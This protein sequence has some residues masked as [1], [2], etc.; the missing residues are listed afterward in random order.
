MTLGSTCQARAPQLKSQKVQMAVSII[1]GGGRGG[2][3]GGGRGEGG[4]GRGEGGGGG[5]GGRGEGVRGGG[6]EAP[7]FMRFTLS[8]M[9]GSVILFDTTAVIL[10][11]AYKL[12]L[13]L[14]TK[15]TTAS[16]MD[17]H[18]LCST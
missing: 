10:C 16:L 4:G 8:N 2:G 13:R 18:V 11:D 3:K 7:Q 5:G 17:G 12:C 15:L 14:C 1:V 6:G 9:L